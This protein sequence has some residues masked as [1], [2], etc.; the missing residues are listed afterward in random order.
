MYGIYL[1]NFE[2]SVQIYLLF[3]NCD[4]HSIISFR[5]NLKSLYRFLLILLRKYFIKN[6]LYYITYININKTI[7]VTI[8][9]CLRIG[10]HF[11][12]NILLRN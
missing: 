7:I 4:C 2:K 10:Y 9:N 8:I 3:N 11:N 1:N 6:V 5:L 12:N